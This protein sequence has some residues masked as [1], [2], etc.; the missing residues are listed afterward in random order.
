MFLNDPTARKKSECDTSGNPLC[1][2]AHVQIAAFPLMSSSPVSS[3]SPFTFTVIIVL[4]GF[5]A[6]FARRTHTVVFFSPPVSS[7]HPPSPCDAPSTAP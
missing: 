4:D 5:G 6:A 7:F 1:R 3:P 2:I